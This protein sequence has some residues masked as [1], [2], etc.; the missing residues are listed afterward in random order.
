[1]KSDKKERN[2]YEEKTSSQ[3]EEIAPPR[4]DAERVQL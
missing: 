4:R 3:T 1:M 2:D